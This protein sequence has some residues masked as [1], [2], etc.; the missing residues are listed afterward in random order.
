MGSRKCRL[1][2]RIIIGWQ[3]YRVPTAVVKDSLANFPHFGTHG[4]F[5]HICFAALIL[6]ETRQNP[7]LLGFLHHPQLVVRGRVEACPFIRNREVWSKGF[8]KGI[9]WAASF[10]NGM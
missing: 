2:M 10:F 8:P 6:S 7:L 4:L 3:Q 5:L 1:H 9:V